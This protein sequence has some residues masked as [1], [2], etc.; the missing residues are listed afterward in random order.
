[1]IRALAIIGAI[2]G[3]AAPA[4]PAATLSLKEIREAGV[5]I[6]QWDTSCAA[7]AMATIFTYSFDDPASERE[8]ARGL[9]RQ[10]EPL[11]VRYRGGFS[12]LDMNR[13][14]ED[15]G[16][17][18]IG[19]RDLGF[20]DVRYL[21]SPIVPV[22][23]NGYKHYVVLKGLT[24]EGDLRIADPAWGNRIISRDY[25]EASWTDGIAFVMWREPQ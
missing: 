21:D 5:V 1:M 16:Y 18:A 3:V 17:R 2:L 14:A 23:F 11:K 6:Q 22:D 4:A 24:P 8:V 20:E 19:F 7:A 15:R 12:M 13:D 9:I 10:T 25:F